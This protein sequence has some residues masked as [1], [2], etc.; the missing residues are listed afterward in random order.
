MAGGGREAESMG[1]ILNKDLVLKVRRYETSK[2]QWHQSLHFVVVVGL[3]LS[4][5]SILVR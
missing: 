5:S 1:E 4:R 3:P 2:K